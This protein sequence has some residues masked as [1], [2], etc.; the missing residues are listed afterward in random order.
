[1]RLLLVAQRYVIS[2]NQILLY[3]VPKSRSLICFTPTCQYIPIVLLQDDDLAKIATQIAVIPKINASRPRTVVITNGSEATIVA[4]S[5]PGSSVKVFP[6]AK[7]SSDEIVDT[8]GAGDCFAGGFIGATVLG[9]GL[10]EAISIGHKLGAMCVGQVGPTLE[11][12]KVD[13]WSSEA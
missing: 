7:L 10:D 13:V 1:M 12:P 2:P 8:N 11:W 6:V 5:A 9:K 4:S 3:Q